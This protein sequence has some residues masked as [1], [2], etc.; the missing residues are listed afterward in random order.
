MSVADDF[1]KI[2]FAESVLDLLAARVVE[3][4][5]EQGGVV[6]PGGGVQIKVES[7]Q[8][9]VSQRVA[10]AVLGRSASWLQRLARQHPEVRR[11][12]RLP[13]QR[14]GRALYSLRR[15]Y[16]LLDGADV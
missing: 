6:L 9:W 14:L 1:N 4:L 2:L 12:M 13:H 10:C 3:R 11:S 7:G 16:E 5:T 8:D 15:V